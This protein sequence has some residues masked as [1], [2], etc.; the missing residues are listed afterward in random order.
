VNAIR[1]IAAAVIRNGDRILVWDDHDPVSGE[2]VAVPL[3]G[4]MEFG[5]TGAAAIAR[6]LGEEIGA[7]PSRVEYLG[8]FEDIFV[9]AGR[10]R[11]EL[12][13]VYDVDLAD[14]R[15]YELDEL[16]VVEPDGRSYPARWR[17][18]DEFRG[19]ARLVPE[20]LLDLIERL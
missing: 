9:W 4:G 6:E 3:A 10:P 16:E 19:E 20:G 2:T 11:H 18:L 8:L 14:R 5:E 13:L 17:P 7:T 1:P 15:V 12:F